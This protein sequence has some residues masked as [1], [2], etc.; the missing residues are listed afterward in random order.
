MEDILAVYR[1]PYDPEEPLVCMDETSK[2][3]VKETRSAVA[4]EP[5]IPA[6]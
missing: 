1:R 3:L 2:Q 4:A 6:L 5:G